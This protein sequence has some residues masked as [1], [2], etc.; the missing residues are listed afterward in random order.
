MFRRAIQVNPPDIEQVRKKARILVVDDQEFPFQSLF[1]R[2]GYHFERWADIRNLSQ[3]TEGHY[4][5]IL[6]DIQ[7]VGLKEDPARQ[8][9]GVLSHIKTTTPTQPVIVYSA[10]PQALSS[11][12]YLAMADEVLDKSESYVTYKECVDRLLL[13]SASPGY[14]VWVMNKELGIDAALAPK[15][16]QFALKA[17]QTGD[18]RRME[19]YLRSSP[20]EGKKISTTLNILQ[21]GIATIQLFTQ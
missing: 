13:R 9:L 1:E 6:L 17:L 3:L 21:L 5:L 15:S 7:G 2:D 18:L 14:F 11:N 16:V 4:Q 12:H 8:G 10:Q 19:R 20:L